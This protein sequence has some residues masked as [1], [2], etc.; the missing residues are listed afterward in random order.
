MPTQNTS[1]V[2]IQII[3]TARHHPKMSLLV[4]IGCGIVAVTY[5]HSI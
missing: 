1:N 3:D 5:L 4:T 2:I